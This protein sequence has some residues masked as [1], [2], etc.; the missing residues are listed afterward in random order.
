MILGMPSAVNRTL[1]G[2]RSRWTIPAW[3]ATWMARARVAISS[4]AWP[5]GLG[6]AGQPVAEA[7]ALEQ[8]ERDEGQAV[9]FADLVDLDDVGMSQPRDRLGLDA[10]ARQVVG[11]R[12]DAAADHLEGDQAVQAGVA[13][14][15]DDAHAPFAQPLEDLVAGDGRPV[16]GH[17][18]PTPGKGQRLSRGGA[19]GPVGVIRFGL[20]AG[21]K[22]LRTP[23]AGCRSDVL[24]R[25]PLGVVRHCLRRRSHPRRGFASGQPFQPL[26]TADALLDVRPNL[27][28]AS[29]SSPPSRNRSSSSSLKHAFIME[30]PDRG[31]SASWHYC[32]VIRPQN[33]S[34][35]KQTLQ[36]SLS[37]FRFLRV[38][39]PE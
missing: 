16:R 12:L 17:R 5:A 20:L 13:G 4:A 21:I 37:I 2:L 22:R 39:L 25:H 29:A 31:A 28:P 3:W 14:L 36:D 24:V 11:P 8:L 10:E 1:V 19:D 27:V 34:A 18:L 6:V 30:S 32:L 33:F 15:V 26:L 9:G 35:G 7:A 38:F 23:A